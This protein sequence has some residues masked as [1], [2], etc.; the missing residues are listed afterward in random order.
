MNSKMKVILVVT[1]TIITASFIWSIFFSGKGRYDKI[2][3]ENAA[4]NTMANKAMQRVMEDELAEII[5]RNLG[6]IFSD[7][8]ESF[9]KPPLQAIDQQSWQFSIDKIRG[10]NIVDSMVA[11]NAIPSWNVQDCRDFFPKRISLQRLKTIDS[12][13]KQISV[14]ES[15]A[16]KGTKSSGKY[17]DVC[18]KLVMKDGT[19]YRSSFFTGANLGTN[20]GASYYTSPPFLCKLTI[21]DGVVTKAYTN[22]AELHHKPSKIEQD[23][24]TYFRVINR[25]IIDLVY[26]YVY[27][28]ERNTTGDEFKKEWDSIRKQ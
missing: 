21:E 15:Y 12:F 6:G 7:Y 1:L 10:N 2:D 19:K 18:I 13:Y 24:L 27:V 23:L 3:T 9:F 11:R 25:F 17:N 20:I 5:Q 26:P 28:P 16:Y 14:L 4:I 8:F 22:T